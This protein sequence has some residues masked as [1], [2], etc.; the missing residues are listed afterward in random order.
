MLLPSQYK[1]N[2]LIF[3]KIRILSYIT[4]FGHQVTWIVSSQ[5]GRQPEQF[6]L[7][8]VEV[9]AIPYRHFFPG[10][11]FL[12]KY[13]NKIAHSFN[14]MRSIL[15]IFREGK[16]DLI[17]VQMT[18]LDVCDGLIASYIR[19]R[20]K[21][22][23]VFDLP[24]PLEVWEAAKLVSPKLRFWDYLFV[25]FIEFAKKCLLHQADLTL[26]ISGRLKD[27]LTKRKGIPESRIMVA[28]EGVDT[29]V[30]SLGD[31]RRV[32]EE[33]Q[34]HGSRV[35][36][37]EGT[38]SKARGLSLLIEAFSKVR[39]EI[40]RVKL[41]VVGEGDDEE[42]LKNLAHDLRIKDDV[43]FT[44]QVPQLEVPDFIAA[45][46]IGLSPVPPTTFYKF[47]SPIKLFE[48]MA[49][50]KP[51]V[52]NE[53]IPEHQNVLEES[54]G[55]VLVPFKHEAFANAIIELILN[56]ER[57]AEMGRRGR[58][59]VVQNRSHEVLARRVEE[60]YIELIQSRGGSVDTT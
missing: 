27:D 13:F 35:M 28:P 8:G 55:G 47:S 44:G 57:A 41:L 3:S 39:M 50:A 17:I 21:V 25:K 23:F 24:N 5:R 26:A 29:E 43:V 16:Y 42:N 14:R 10:N 52:A 19:R 56:P 51:V 40:P 30:F 22:P 20:Y 11:I 6:S 38:L 32:A 53:E 37:Y 1:P 12:A 9:Y 49:M 45:A 2:R 34:F 7:D 18:E 54:G 15:K 31:P 48:Y 58:E 59:W 4:R 36:I 60:R 46:D 33:Y